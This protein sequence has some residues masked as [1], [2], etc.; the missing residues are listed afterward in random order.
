M[1][2]MMVYEDIEWAMGCHMEVSHVVKRRRRGRGRGGGEGGGG[3]LKSYW[4]GDGGV[5][6]GAAYWDEIM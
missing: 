1:F 2:N 3:G 6:G 5:L 4:A